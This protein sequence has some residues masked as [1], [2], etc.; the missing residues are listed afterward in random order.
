M[1]GTF[2]QV[3]EKKKQVKIAKVPFFPPF[4]E[5]EN[6]NISKM[7]STT[8]KTLHFPQ[9]YQYTYPIKLVANLD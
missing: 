9:T 3:N 7:L 6:A 1:R 8:A 2:S 4:R 5:F